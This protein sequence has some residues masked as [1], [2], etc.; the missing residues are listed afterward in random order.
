VSRSGIA[1]FTYD[2]LTGEAVKLPFATFETVPVDVNGDAIH[3]LIRR[4]PDGRSELIDRRGEV[5]GDFGRNVRGVLA[6]KLLARPGEQILS[7]NPEGQVYVWYDANA[8]DTPAAQAR[9][10]HPLYRA[11]RRLGATGS[12][13]CVLGGIY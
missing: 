10:N 13:R 12:N 3:E 4:T 8:Q 5:L 2:A 11:N 1:E 9:Y 6:C 7:Y